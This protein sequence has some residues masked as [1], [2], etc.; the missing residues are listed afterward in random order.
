MRMGYAPLLA[1]LEPIVKRGIKRLAVIGIPCQV[2]ALRALEAELGFERLYVIGTPCSD[3]T[4][5]ENFH[6]FL[7]LLDDRPDDHLLSR[8]PR[9]LP[10]RAALRR[11]PPDPRDPVSQAA[12]LEAARRLLPADLPHLRR[13]HERPVRRD[14]RLYGR[15]LAGNG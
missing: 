13:L 11:R 7:D 2:Y 14:G 1:L 10:R 9:R 6:T 4:T 3:N 12:D 15:R 5:T 8:I